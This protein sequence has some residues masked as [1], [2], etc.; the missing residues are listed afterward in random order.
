L[1]IKSNVFPRFFF[2][3]SDDLLMLLAQTKDPRA[4]QPHMDKCFEGIQRICFDVNERVYAMVSAEQ[5]EVA[6]MRKVDV[7]EGNKKGN[8]EVWMLEIED[9]MIKTLRSKTKEANAD[10]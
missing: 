7:N 6:L 9:I 3:A 5:E 2:L 4:V 8:V 1:E 10:Y